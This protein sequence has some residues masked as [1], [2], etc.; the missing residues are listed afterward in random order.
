MDLILSGIPDVI[1]YLDDILI[2]G[3]SGTQHDER[4]REVLTRLE[5]AGIHLKTDKCEFDKAQVEY[6]GH[7]VSE[8]GLKPTE[9]KVEAIKQAPEPTNVTELKA[10]LGLVNYYGRFL[11]NLSSLLEPLYT[12][13][14]KDKPWKWTGKERKA[15]E[16]TKKKLLAS[17]FFTHYDLSKP[18]RLS[19]DAS[20][21]GVGACLSHVMEDGTEQPVAFASWTLSPTE[22][23]YAQ[24]EKEAL[25]LIFGVRQFHKYL[26][27]RSFTLVT[28]HRPLLKILGPKEGIPTLAAARLQRWALIL[29]AYSYDLEYIQG[30]ENVEADMLSRL[31]LPVTV[32]DENEKVYHIDYCEQLPVVAADVAKQTQEDP[33]LRRVCQYTQWGWKSEVQRDPLL[34]PYYHRSNELSIEDGCLLWAGRVVIPNCLRKL[35][36]E[37]LH[38]GHAG[39]KAIARSFIWWPGI[40]REVEEVVEACVTCQNRRSRPSVTPPHPWTYSESPWQRASPC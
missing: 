21:S 33:I 24:L 19:C 10:F 8:Q 23:K 2:V 6:L 27:G 37:E 38:E 39:M 17:R 34:K 30:V 3:S 40:D 26:I 1:C 32:V 25:A 16:E 13:L 31:P 35:V 14:Q 22:K 20:S 5:K 29:S 11:Q 9:R 18:L 28:D 12:L 7:I 36:L 4:L 15:F